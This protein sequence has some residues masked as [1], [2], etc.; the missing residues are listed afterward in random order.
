MYVSKMQNRCNFVE[1][2]KKKRYLIRDNRGHLVTMSRF[3]V[4][5]WH[6]TLSCEQIT[7]EDGKDRDLYV[8]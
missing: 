7:L 8:P 2:R 5:E 1:K 3:E 4:L 6:D